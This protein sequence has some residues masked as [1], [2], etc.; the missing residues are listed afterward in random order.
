V[1]G[2]FLMEAPLRSFS[3]AQWA[4]VLGPRKKHRVI[5]I[6]LFLTQTYQMRLIPMG[7]MILTVAGRAALVSAGPAVPPYLRSL[8][9]KVQYI[10]DVGIRTTR[11]VVRKLRWFAAQIEPDGQGWPSLPA[12]QLLLYV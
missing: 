10:K 7:F 11:R 1:N 12:P 5:G 9:H 8:N 4:E 6:I 2:G 3:P